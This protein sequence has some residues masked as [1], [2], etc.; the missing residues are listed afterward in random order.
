MK[1]RIFI[2]SSSEALDVAK[3]IKDFF[4]SDYECFLWTD[5]V[6]KNNESFLETLVKSASLFDFGFMVFSADDKGTI[7]NEHFE[8]PRDNILFEYGLFLGR[9]GL[10]RA[11]IIA[12]E[13][14][15]IPTDMLGITHTRYIVETDEQG[16]KKATDSLERGL[17]TLKKQIEENLK[18]GHL[19][20]L[21]STV[22]A[23]SYFEGF[24]KLAAE[25]IMNG[26][27]NIGL[28]GKGCKKCTLYIKMPETLDADIK[29]SAKLFYKKENLCEIEIKTA[30]RNYPIHFEAKYNTDGTLALYDMPTILS[31]IDKAIDMYFE[32][33]HIGKTNQQQLAEDNEM[34][35]FKRVLQLLINGDAFCR[36]CV[37][38]I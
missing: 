3:R 12:E 30:H 25:S 6:F 27:P 8:T 20:L 23:I 7:R 38:I 5:D 21:P 36:E 34:N 11:Y 17:E 13:T 35:N 37:E 33:G 29:K 4:S 14:V 18:L 1:P 9:V 16:E 19:G 15:R 24:V 28:E 26:I 10:D 32:V 22:I 2:G 31:G